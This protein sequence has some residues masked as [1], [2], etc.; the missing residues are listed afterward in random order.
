MLCQHCQKRPATTY[1]SE[2]VNGHQQELYL[3]EVCAAQHHSAFFDVGDFMQGFWGQTP[4]QSGKRCE[5]CGMSESAF[6]KSGKF[7]CG[8]CART[9]ADRTHGVLKQIHG[10]SKHVGKVPSHGQEQLHQQ[11]ELEQLEKR[12]QEAIAAERY[13][14]AAKLRDAIRDLKG[15]K[16]GCGTT[17]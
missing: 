6:L 8:K 15:G 2:T 12:L 1:L 14:E 17:K 7:G 5:G 10:R 9:F 3:C 4:K 16:G 13:E 11:R